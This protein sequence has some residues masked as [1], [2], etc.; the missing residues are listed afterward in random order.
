M[1]TAKQI[2]QIADVS[3]EHSLLSQ[4][5]T[6]FLLKISS[7]LALGDLITTKEQ[8]FLDQIIDILSIEERYNVLEQKLSEHTLSLFKKTISNTNEDK[9]NSIVKNEA[10]TG[11][12]ARSLENKK[13]ISFSTFSE[14]TSVFFKYKEISGSMTL[15][16]NQDHIFYEKLMK[17]KNSDAF[18]FILETLSAWII[19][20]SDCHS[21]KEAEIL[22]ESREFWGKEL[23]KRLRSSDL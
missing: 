23:R 18:D 10:K 6:Q 12:L 5:D 7:K 17:Y 9:Y 16:I 13:N 3:L 19:Y 20:E 14:D 21:N 4:T 8:N 15:L 1:F 22:K 2:A 11:L